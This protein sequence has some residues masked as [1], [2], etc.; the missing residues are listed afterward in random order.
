MRVNKVTEDKK[1][2]KKSPVRPSVSRS[3]S[4]LPGVGP[5]RQHFQQGAPDFPVPGYI[6]QLWLRDPKAF[7]GQ[8]EDIIAPPG[9]GS[10]LVPP[11]SWTYLEQ[12]P[13]EVTRR[14]PYH[15][16]EPPQ[17]GPFSTESITDY[18][19]FHLI[20]RGEA[21]PTA[22][23]IQPISHSLVPLLMNQTPRYLNSF[24]WCKDS[25]TT[26][27]E[28]PTSLILFWGWFAMFVFCDHHDSV[29]HENETR[30]RW[31]SL[32]MTTLHNPPLW[33][34]L[35]SGQA[36]HFHFFCFVDLALE[37]GLKGRDGFFC[38]R[39]LSKSSLLLLVSLTIPTPALSHGH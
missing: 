12:L 20:P 30:G 23:I 39:I 16:P 34:P 8:C 18:L 35:S 33:F 7:L 2:G 1:S 38:Y 27:S 24:T 19:T 15:M 37:G 36:E 29:L 10:A 21:T 26:W 4:L 13:R 14:H 25:F 11:L 17:L 6:N 32:A 9:T 5:W 22:L 31:T 28:Q 3:V